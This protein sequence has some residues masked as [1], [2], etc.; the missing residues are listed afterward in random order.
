M[1]GSAAFVALVDRLAGLGRARI[2][3]VGGPN[4]YRFAAERPEGYRDGFAADGIAAD[5][6]LAHAT[7]PSDVDGERARDLVPGRDVPAPA[8][9]GGPPF[10]GAH[11]SQRVHGVQNRAGG[12]AGINGLKT[13][14][15]T[16][17][18]TLAALLPS[19][20]ATTITTSQA[21]AD[22]IRFWTT[23]G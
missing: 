16:I 14:T 6:A 5:D 21:A 9:S 22:T 12:A 2:G 13:M 19:A 1:D 10:G 20:S 11:R 17:G 4:C 15:N 8:P 7:D 23:E 18:T 3:H